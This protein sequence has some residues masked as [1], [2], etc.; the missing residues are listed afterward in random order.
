MTQDSKI[1]FLSCRRRQR[2]LRPGL[3]MKATKL[4]V[5]RAACVHEGMISL[6]AYVVC[7]KALVLIQSS[8]A[9]CQSWETLSGKRTPATT[10][11]MSR[12]KS[13][14]LML[15][16]AGAEPPPLCLGRYPNDFR[17]KANRASSTFTMRCLNS[18]M[19]MAHRAGHRPARSWAFLTCL[20]LRAG[21]QPDGNNSNLRASTYLVLLQH[22]LPQEWPQCDLGN[23]MCLTRSRTRIAFPRV[24][25]QR[26]SGSV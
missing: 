9:A 17:M 7:S 15:V 20:D 3:L 2:E 13:R 6:P 26:I 16:V 14:T 19:L 10:R 5:G 25:C 24:F 12:R 8:E 11:P 22:L 21:S 4:I 23:Q 18:I 1:C